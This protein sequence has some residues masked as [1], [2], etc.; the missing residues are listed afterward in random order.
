MS[1]ATVRANASEVGPLLSR[2][3][4]LI[5]QFNPAL[6]VAIDLFCI[7]LTAIIS[8]SAYDYYAYGGLGALEAYAWIGFAVALVHVLIEN[9]NGQYSAI[10]HRSP[11]RFSGLA[12]RWALSFL[13]IS[14]GV[15]FLKASDSVSRGMLALFFLQGLTALSMVRLLVFYIAGSGRIAGLSQPT[16]VVIHHERLS[17]RVERRMAQL[18]I[19]VHAL[20]VDDEMLDPSR[21][22]ELAS[23]LG[24]A[25]LAWQAQAV[26]VTA[27]LSQ[28]PAVA[29]LIDGLSNL[30]API[31]FIPT[32]GLSLLE[33]RSTRFGEFAAFEARP[34]P[35]APVDRFVK[36]GID[37]LGAT[38]GLLLFAPVF[39]LIAVLIK[40]DSRGPVFFRQTR[41][42]IG[43]KPFRIWKFRTMSVQEDGPV[44]L[45]ATP[46]DP[47]VTAIGRILRRTSLDELPQ[48]LNELKGDMSLVGPRPHACAHDH[49]YGAIIRDYVWRQHVKPGIT[50]WAQ[51]HGFRGETRNLD[52][53]R[54]RIELDCWYIR[55]FSLVLDLKILFMTVT[56]VLRDEAAY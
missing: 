54:R 33:G 34:A 45:Q 12:A 11:T 39:L 24:H 43:R 18:G 40:M 26:Y 56:L 55:N 8:G 31:S 25:C 4:A 9:L 15:T 5:R 30:P 48:L 16:V 27:P 13:V 14:S 7:V 36:R 17:R 47:R 20:T 52:Q 2:G 49:E 29:R 21:R 35:C 37:I 41:H 42:G 38:L 46:D 53:M 23:R 28:A 1:T 50:G 10:V 19:T 6:L 3:A 32:S 22:E 44:V 51:V